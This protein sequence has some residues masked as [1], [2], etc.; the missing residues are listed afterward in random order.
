LG[1]LALLVENLG[2]LSI[3][4]LFWAL[5][6]GFGGA[7]FLA[8]YFQERSNWWAL[9]PGVILIAI[10]V[11]ILLG[12]LFPAI[13]GTLDG[14][15]V[16]GGIGFSFILVYLLN[17]EHWWAIIPAGVLITLGVVSLFDN[18]VGLDTGGLFF[19]G[20]G[21]TFLCLAWLPGRQEDLRWAYIP[22]G[23]TLV[24][25]LLILAA[26]STLMNILVPGALIIAGGYVLIRNLLVKS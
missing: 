4:G 23:I 9:I 15:L 20:I 21:L 11:N 7:A 6:L 12:V 13:A 1:G 26:S 18:V 25:G 19:I 2:W 22:G 8:E 24:L 3:G 14:L 17:R 10:A 5:I 16:L